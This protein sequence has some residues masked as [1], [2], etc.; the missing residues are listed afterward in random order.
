MSVRPMLLVA[1]TAIAADAYTTYAALTTPSKTFGEAGPGT[2]A[3]IS[4]HGLIAG[5]AI[6]ATTRLLLFTLIALLA[7]RLRYQWPLVAIGYAGATYTAWLAAS[8]VWT[9]THP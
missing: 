3:L 4:S 1:A 2:A 6:A 5:I 7:I 9:V 8:N